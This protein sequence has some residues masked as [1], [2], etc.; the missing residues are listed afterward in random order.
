[1]EEIFPSGKH[2]ASENEGKFL[3]QRRLGA[4][5]LPFSST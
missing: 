1:M 5:G 4:P 2:M 3:P